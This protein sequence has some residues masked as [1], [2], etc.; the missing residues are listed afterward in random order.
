MTMIT[1]IVIALQA[2]IGVASFLFCWL[3]VAFGEPL[4]NFFTRGLFFL[5]VAIALVMAYALELHAAAPRP[6]VPHAQ[7]APA[8][9]AWGLLTACEVM[10]AAGI[11]QL[12]VHRKGGLR[13]ALAAR[14]SRRR[15]LTVDA[16]AITSAVALLDQ[17]DDR[18]YAQV[19]GAT[20]RR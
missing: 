19:M 11:W 3:F 9:V 15:A 16:D 20:R 14:R 8:I 1:D 5:Q 17:L 4:R 7:Q 18:E 13:G 10:L 6:P 2:A 12:L